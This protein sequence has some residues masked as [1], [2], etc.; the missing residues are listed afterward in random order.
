MPAQGN[1]TLEYVLQLATGP[2][3]ADDDRYAAKILATI[4]GDDS[5]SR[6]YWALVDRDWPN[7]PAL[8]TTTIR[9]PGCS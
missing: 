9:A 1:R 2:A 8:A 7:K 6:L 3:A 5:G 4:L